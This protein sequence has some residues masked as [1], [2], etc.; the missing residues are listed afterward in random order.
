MLSDGEVNPYEL[1]WTQDW[2]RLH[3]LQA[4]IM[5][6]R[7]VYN[8]QRPHQALRWQTPHERRNQQLHKP[9]ALAS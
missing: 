2:D 5:A 1:F 9:L 7:D 8:E 6:W 4:A 3:D